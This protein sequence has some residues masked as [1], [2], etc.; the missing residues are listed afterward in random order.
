MEGDV[1][2]VGGDDVKGG[3]ETQQEARVADVALER[4]EDVL[5]CLASNSPRAD[6]VITCEADRVR[7]DVHADR[8]GAAWWPETAEEEGDAARAGAE[9]E[10]AHGAGGGASVS[11]TEG[12]VLGFWA[13]DEGRGAGEEV[14]GPKGGRAWSGSARGPGMAKRPTEDVLEGFPA[15]SAVEQGEDIWSRM[16]QDPFQLV[17]RTLAADGQREFCESTLHERNSS[18]YVIYLPARSPPPRVLMEPCLPSH[19][20][21]CP[22]STPPT[23][24]PSSASPPHPQSDAARPRQTRAATPPPTPRASTETG[25][26][27]KRP[28][29]PVHTAKR[30]TSPVTTVR[31]RPSPRSLLT[32]P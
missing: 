10:D 6:G 28:T 11:E 13:G 26:R 5:G 29:A 19:P 4:G 18:D 2:R 1:R 21:T 16:F 14:E 17:L 9:V 30:P 3:V 7:G 20:Q 24:T 15:Q 23:W 25:P 32:P 12:P 22:T 27:R 31:A 8:A